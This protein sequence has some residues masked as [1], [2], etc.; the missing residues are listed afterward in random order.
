MCAST[1]HL[2]TGHTIC[3][4]PSHPYPSLIARGTH[5]LSSPCPSPTTAR[6]HHTVRL[7]DHFHALTSINKF[8]S[9]TEPG[10]SAQDREIQTRLAVCQYK[11]SICV[12]QNRQRLF[13]LPSTVNVTSYRTS[14][15][16][17]KRRRE[18]VSART[19]CTYGGHQD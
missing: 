6:G 9:K 3:T 4:C 8:V 19:I 18:Q 10:I 14:I 15:S 13:S 17:A 2:L 5:R 12:R 16:K 1:A 11:H 7:P